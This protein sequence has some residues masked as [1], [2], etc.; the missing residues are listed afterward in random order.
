MSQFSTKYLLLIESCA[1]VIEKKDTFHGILVVY[2]LLRLLYAEMFVFLKTTIIDE[3]CSK[4][5]PSKLR[6]KKG[7]YN[8]N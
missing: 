2:W 3:R 8:S 1:F 6:L 4:S 5:S 7:Q